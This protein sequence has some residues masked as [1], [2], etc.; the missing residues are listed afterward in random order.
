VERSRIR[1]AGLVAGLAVIAL[2]VTHTIDLWLLDRD[3]AWLEAGT[4][5][6]VFEWTATMTLGLCA[7]AAAVLALTSPP[8]RRI[9][10][11]LAGGLAIVF[12][13]DATALTE[14]VGAGG[15]A[16]VVLILASVFVLLWLLARDL[17][18]RGGAV[19]AGLLLL[20]LSVA[21]RVADIISA[22]DWADG[23]VGDEAKVVL[24]HGSELAGWILIAFGLVPAALSRRS[25]TRSREAAAGAADSG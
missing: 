10:L 25:L 6:S 15:D 12:L 5:N 8:H 3:A 4:G 9:L 14:K 2:A 18:E 7:V 13:T 16:A 17:G 21:I 23:D 24:K 20:A 22:L 19:R 1:T 11:P